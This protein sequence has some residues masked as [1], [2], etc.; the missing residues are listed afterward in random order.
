[1][2]LPIYCLILL[3][4][5]FLRMRNRF[6]GTLN[7]SKRSEIKMVRESDKGRASRAEVE[8]LR[9]GL[10]RKIAAYVHTEGPVDTAVPGLIL[11]RR[12]APSE[13][14]CTTYEPELVVFAQGE[15][16]ITVGG[17]T[18]LCDGS[19]FLLTSVDLPV[20][21]QI[22]KASKSEPYLA[23]VLKL[24]MPVVREIL[25]QDEFPVPLVPSG[26]RGMAVGKTPVELLRACSRL[27]DLLDTP[28]DIPFLGSLMQREILYRLLRS[29]LGRN[30]RSIATLGEQSNRTAKAVGWLRSNFDKPLR[31]QE[32][33][34]VA[35]MGVSTLH[36]HFRSLTAMSPLQYQKRLRLHTA[37]VRMM[38]SGLD[39][40][41]AAFEVG[42]ES[43]SQFNREY[44]RLFGQPPMRDIKAR[45]SAGVASENDSL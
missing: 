43:A 44:S 11:S 25:S 16:R 12:T 19:S 38:T 42:Y 40:A 39:A 28:N 18:H 6:R 20:E 22:I 45:R 1:L 26:A 37:R 7:L 9:A 10:A 31:V 33:A 3:S 27:L 14:F 30:L 24:E 35:Q 21:S 4:N 2:I 17:T 5:D 29:P 41:S 8:E 36:H 34:S 32:L 15:K 23:M 13:F